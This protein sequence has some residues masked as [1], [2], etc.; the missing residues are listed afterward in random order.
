MLTTTA[1]PQ[2]SCLATTNKWKVAQLLGTGRKNKN[3]YHTPYD[4]LG[5]K[6]MWKKKIEK[7]LVPWLLR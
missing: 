2:Q 1:H 5:V 4:K 7:R 3:I 6:E